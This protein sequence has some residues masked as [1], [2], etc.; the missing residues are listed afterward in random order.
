MNP[1]PTPSHFLPLG[2]LESWNGT[3]PR[4]QGGFTMFYL[5]KITLKLHLFVSCSY[6][7]MTQFEVD[8]PKLLASKRFKQPN[9]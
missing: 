9:I 6:N 2:D 1:V 3:S 5:V 7:L 8:I 4:L